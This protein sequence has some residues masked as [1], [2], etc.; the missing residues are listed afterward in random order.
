MILIENNTLKIRHL[1]NQLIKTRHNAIDWS[2]QVRFIDDFLI[3]EYQGIYNR[4]KNEL[5][6]FD[7]R[8]MM[9]KCI[10]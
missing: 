3:E 7:N 6:Y 1:K 5:Y 2:C 9:L 4:I 8:K 10:K